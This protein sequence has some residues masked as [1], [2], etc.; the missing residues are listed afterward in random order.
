ML[1]KPKRRKLNPE[2]RFAYIDDAELDQKK[3]KLQHM[4]TTKADE[5]AES[6]L[7]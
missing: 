2:E 7:M 4:N 6:I 3:M 1:K 5:K